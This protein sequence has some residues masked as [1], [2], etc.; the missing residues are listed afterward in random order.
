MRVRFASPLDCTLVH[1]LRRPRGSGARGRALRRSACNER[2]RGSTSSVMCRS[3]VDRRSRT[4]RSRAVGPRGR[5]RRRRARGP[6]NREAGVTPARPPPLYPGTKAEEPLREGRSRARAREPPSRGKV[7]PRMIR[8][9]GNLLRRD[10]IAVSGGEHAA[11]NARTSSIPAFLRS[12]GAAPPAGSHD[13]AH[14][15]EGAG[16]TP[17]AEIP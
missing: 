6:V 3:S 8:E 15:P 2:S 11:A 4:R 5:R 12:D 7:R 10:A 9:P 14:E 1:G 13:P 17:D 16:A